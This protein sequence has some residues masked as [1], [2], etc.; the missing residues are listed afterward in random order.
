ME[1]SKYTYFL[2]FLILDFF[3]VNIL[4]TSIQKVSLNE[5]Y[6]KSELIFQGQVI[7]VEPRLDQN[8]GNIRTDITFKIIEV[9]KG[10]KGAPLL[11][12]SFLGGRVGNQVMEVHGMHLP[13][14]GEN[15]IYFVESLAREQV[16]PIMGWSQGHFI[17]EKDLTGLERITTWDNAPVI[18]F[19]S[20]PPSTNLTIS[21]DGHVSGIQLAN[22]S[23]LSN[24]MTPDVFKQHL[25]SLSR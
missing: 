9:I 25:R 12:I 3:S 1:M 20:F 2:I 6:N 24:A 23:K 8:T 15:G 4:A 11:K 19:S 14:K 17:I 10:I 13:Q 5:A 7:K 18:G 21:T 16:N 22:P